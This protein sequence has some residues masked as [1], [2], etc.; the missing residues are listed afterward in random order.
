[1]TPNGITSSTGLVVPFVR[2][3]SGRITKITDP[4]GNNYL[5]SYDS[6]GNLAS[7]TYPP[8]TQTTTLCPNTTL[9]NTSTYTYD[10]NHLYT[11]GTD[12]RCNILPTAAYYGS[13]DLDPNGLPLNGRLQSVTD[14]YNETTSYAYNL[15]TDT[16]TVT[17]PAD[18]S[19]NVGTATM[20]YDSYGDLV[21]STDPLGHITT[22]VYDA[23]H[24]LILVTDPLSHATTYTYDANG[25][26]TSST[27]PSLGT[28]H[29]TTS[30]TY[31]N[32]YSEPTSTIDELGNVRFFNYDTNFLPQSVTDSS[33]TLASFI[34][35]ANSTLEAGAIGFDISANPAQASQFTYDANGNMA[36]RTDALGRTTSYTYDSLGHKLSTTAP[37]PA[38][39]TGTA[40]STTT[41]Q[42]DALGNLTSTA[43]PLS[44]TTGSTYD[45]NGNKLSD[46]GARGNTTTYQY[47]ALNRLIE[48]DYPTTPVTKSTK[49]Y[50]FR[51]N[52][53]TDTDQAGN[54]TQHVYDK[55]GRQTSVT[56]GYGSSTP[57]TTSTTYRDDG[58]K[59]S[60]TDALGHTTSYSYD[61]AGRLTA[62][63]GVKGNITY[64][65]DDAGNQTSRTD[66]NANTTQ[67]Q[68][69][70]R[71]RLVKTINPDNTTIVN[72]YDGP[73]N[74]ASVTDQAGNIVQYT[75]DAANQ[76]KTVVQV[77]HPNPSNNTNFYSYDPLGN[78][79]GLTD[80]N[81]HTT[82][83]AYDVL[84]EPIQKTLPV[85]TLT[86]TRQYDQA[87]NLAQLTHFNGV[88]TSY[89]YDALNRLLTRATPGEATVSFTYTAIGKYLTSMAQDGTVHYTYDALDR[90]ITKATPEGT[91]SYTFDAA[92]HVASIASSNPNGVS[93]SYTYDD[94]NRLSTV[95][96]NRLSGN[97]TT[98]YAYDPASNVATAAYPNG[99]TSTFT[100]DQLNRL[101]ELSTSTQPITDYKYTLGLTGNRTN[102]TE[103]S[104][105]TLQWSYDNIYRLTGETITSDP[106]DN[107]GN[108]GSA[109]YTLDPVGNRTSATST[110]SGINPIAGS[111]NAAD[112]LSAESY[113]ANGNTTYSGGKSFTYDSENH[114]MS[115]T[116]GSTVVS[117][118]YDAFG[119][120]VS[121][122]A[123][124][125]LTSYLVEDDVNPTGY[126]QVM[127]EI[128]GGP[129][130]TAVTRSYTYG[131]QRI[132]E[133]QVI[134]GAWTPSFYGY[135]GAGSV[136]QLTNS[137]G[138]VTDG[139]EYDAFGNSFTKVGTTPNNYLYRGEQYDA[140][141][142]LYYLRA[143]YY[144]PNT[145]RF[146]SRDPLDGDATDPRTLHKYE[147][148]G[149]DPV[150]MA[151]PTGREAM[152]EYVE[153]GTIAIKAKQSLVQLSAAINCL[154][155]WDTTKFTSWVEVGIHGGTAKQVSACDWLWVP[156]PIDPRL[157]KPTPIKWT[158]RGTNYCGPGGNGTPTNSVDWACAKHD[159]CYQDAGISFY[160]NVRGNMTPQQQAAAQS[161]DAGLCQEMSNIDD[162]S[163]PGFVGV[164]SYFCPGVIRQVQSEFGAQ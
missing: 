69:D 74:L 148:A 21:T 41:Y 63:A 101:T 164:I 56:H 68:Y 146:L 76:L 62:V 53:L 105:R 55:G 51:N 130:S 134:Q 115:M 126:P 131:L 52:V 38:S 122:T 119:N 39:L 17:Y 31:Y 117:M 141:L 99:L 9:P 97:N 124:G 11:G 113:D 1:V 133:N 155:R 22:N 64:G 92:G 15:A 40:A 156:A 28:G 16:T 46:T 138:T 159:K 149:G 37:T 128:A 144:N 60:E 145:G 3:S 57:S 135:D 26:K 153:V 72:T 123:N 151:D 93:V 137:A 162:P 84:M 7:V 13:A 127:E 49:T 125:V 65:Y 27:Y 61:A 90:L 34:F 96:D 73:G 94:L 75:Y 71:K 19:G 83:N 8:T 150:N 111:Y 100:Y 43:A 81:L 87:G 154:Y 67:L 161:C 59:Q 33:G 152:F 95:A 163:E 5:Y 136:R 48:T 103:Q 91:L 4:Q 70:A 58:R 86:E 12:G 10:T 66:A 2:D 77:N 45:A 80:E 44:R 112:Q 139:Y 110:L 120:R 89:T 158:F 109:T 25:N 132:S 129:G 102:A 20:V 24:N 35:N 23:N 107:N 50:D 106:T 98:T 114:L 14:A 160:N 108:N 147:Y 30:T 79:T 88:T 142:S 118:M 54:V 18:A 29:N 116:S 47:D 85:Q 32:Q 104:G 121:K 140:D 78:L 42:Y 36:S 143:R 6:S 82:R 157:P